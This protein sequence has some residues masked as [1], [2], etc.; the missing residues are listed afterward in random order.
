MINVLEMKVLNVTIFKLK[1]K[2]SDNQ[3]KKFTNFLYK[4]FIKKKLPK[5]K[6]SK[7]TW[8]YT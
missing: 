5:K 1:V 2:K 4:N 7:I 3:E 6:T 8:I